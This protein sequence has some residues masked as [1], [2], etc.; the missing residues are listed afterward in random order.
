MSDCLTGTIIV[1]SWVLAAI[2]FACGK[3]AA[4]LAWTAMK[5]RKASQGRVA[6]LHAW[7]ADVMPVCESWI[8]KEISAPVIA[9]AQKIAEKAWLAWKPEQVEESEE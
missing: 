7:P 4:K 2:G 5:Q 8:G 9:E 3:D 1:A 6:P